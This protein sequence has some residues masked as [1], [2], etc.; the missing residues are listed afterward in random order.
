MRVFGFP[1][2]QQLILPIPPVYQQAGESG[3]VGGWEHVEPL[4]GLLLR[5]VH[6]VSRAALEPQIPSVQNGSRVQIRSNGTTFQVS[7]V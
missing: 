2:S 5:H 4:P 6:A 3:Y 1:G 7:Y